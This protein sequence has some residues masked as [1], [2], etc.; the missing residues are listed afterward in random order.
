MM[1]S[2]TFHTLDIERKGVR[3]LRELR[4]VFQLHMLPLH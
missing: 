2:L 3:P 4:L 1:K